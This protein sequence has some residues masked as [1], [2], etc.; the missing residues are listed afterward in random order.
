MT[1]IWVGQMLGAI[2]DLGR[3]YLDR[4]TGAST[5]D[6]A[7][8]LCRDLMSD[9]GEASGTAL[10]REV[11]DLYDRMADDDRLTL[12]ERLSEIYAPDLARLDDA[13][14]TYLD[15]HDQEALQGLAAAIAS[16]RQELFRRLNMAP[17]GT[18][19]IV[20]IRQ[21]LL[22]EVAA[23]P[24]LGPLEHDIQHLLA[25][26]FNRG[27]LQFERIDWR[28]PAV[29]LEKLIAYEAVHAIQGWE[30]LRRRLAA[31]RRCFAFFHP[32]LPD[33]PLIFVEVALTKGMAGEIHALLDLPPVDPDAAL[34]DTAIFYSISNCQAGLAGITFGNFLIKQVVDALSLELPRVRRFATLS[35]IPGFRRW[36]DEQIAAGPPDAFSKTDLEILADAGWAANDL[37][38]QKLKRPLMRLCARFLAREQR[39]GRPL[40]AVARFHIGNGASIERINWM[41]DRS[42]KGL[43]QSLGMMVNYLYD[44]DD[45]IANHEAYVRDGTI[46]TSSSVRGLLSGRARRVLT[47]D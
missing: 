44:A 36:L 25:S 13:A 43:A 1:R 31:D 34:P 11:L 38:R 24:A 41:A 33:E 4:P 2:A 6:N 46:A 42:E 14:I 26:W 28:T 35:P 7:L 19:A 5:V 18:A 23:R 10:A 30:D 47:A 9:H 37:A 32:A 15:T 20:E 8:A 3:Q 17:G 22:R 27:F 16:P 45:I 39:G 40:D 21:L 12:F 29:I